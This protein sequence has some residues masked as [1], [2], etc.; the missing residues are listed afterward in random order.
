MCGFG[1]S[2]LTPDGGFTEDD[3]RDWYPHALPWGHELAQGAL[4]M[5]TASDD[6]SP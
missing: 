1:S 4:L 6:A 5:S 3:M 2:R